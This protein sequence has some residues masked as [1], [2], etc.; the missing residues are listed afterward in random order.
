MNTEIDE[1]QYSR[2]LHTFGAEAQKALEHTSVLISGL[3]GLGVEI[4]KC[5]I[6][7]GV[8]SLTLH[9]TKVVDQI[10]L[11][12]NYYADLSDVGKMRTDVVKSKLSSLNPKVNVQI[13][14]DQVLTD[15]HA[16]RHQVVVICDSTIAEQIA[17]N[18]LF[19][20]YGTKY[21]FANTLGLFGNVFC[22]FGDEFIVSDPDG[23]TPV[24]GI[25]TNIVNNEFISSEP[26]KLYVGD[27]I[28]LKIGEIDY[29]D[30]VE[31]IVDLTT[32]KIKTHK[33]DNQ[34]LY[35][36]SFTQQK[37]PLTMNFK[38]LSLAITNPE[39]STVMIEDWDRQRLL[40]DWFVSVDKFVCI[41]Q[42]YP[43]S[44]SSTDAAEILQTI[45]CNN[46][47]QTSVTNLL[48]YTAKGK[49]VEIDSIIAPIV[50]QEVVK[51]ASKKYTPVKQF[52]YI[53]G[54]N[55]IPNAILPTEEFT[56]LPV[57]R[58]TG[59]YLVFGKT[60]QKKIMDSRVFVVGA[61]AI[62][63]E[64][65]KN[66]AMMGV[67][68]IVI[69]DMDTIEKSNLNRQFLFR[70]SDI[71]KSKSESA[72]NAINQMNPNITVVAQQNKV[73]GDTISVYN[74]HFFSQFSLVLTALDNVDAR[75]FVDFLC[76]QH[77]VPLIDAGTLGT[78]GNIQIVVP[79]LTETYG[80]SRDP[81]EK[82]IPMCTLKN[83]PYMIEHCIQWARDM[84]EGLFV[85]APQDFMQYKAN[86][87]KYTSLTE[88]DRNQLT[89][90][91]H[92][93]NF[94]KNNM[95]CHIKECVQIAYKLWHEHFRDHI[96]H[97]I[98]KFPEFS[99]T[100]EN[101][102]FWVGTKKFP[103]FADFTGTAI[104]MAFLES[105]ANLW[106]QVCGLNKKVTLKQLQ[107]FVE[108]STP[109]VIAG[110]N[111][112]IAENKMELAT[113]KP[114][115]DLINSL[116]SAHDIEPIIVRPLEFEKDDDTNFH[117]DFVTSASNSRATNYSIPIADKFKTKCI[118]GKI[119][120]AIVTTTSLVSGLVM[121]E[122]IKV[123][124]NYNK[125]EKYS[126][127][128]VNLALPVL[129]FSD[130]I[131]IKSNKVGNFAYTIWDRITFDDMTVSDLMLAIS[132]L[133][134]DDS[135]H[136]TAISSGPFQLFSL[137][138][139]NKLINERKLMKISDIYQ[140]IT[141]DGLLQMIPIMAEIEKIDAG[142]DMDVKEL[143]ELYELDELEDDCEFLEC[144]INRFLH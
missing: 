74:E 68:T 135:K 77:S 21:I 31:K 87:Q 54:T 73:C 11:S 61:G 18:E 58:Y 51:A 79:H 57:D 113:G 38:P 123:L 98:N 43:N 83:F 141:N 109:P 12:S 71:G 67:G 121:T 9:D 13:S 127:A 30:E 34:L 130:P 137:N 4:A 144:R 90:V 112:V 88:A 95:A 107:Q 94:V 23:E 52:M 24:F 19:R 2:Q 122:Y 56:D 84:F 48:S 7:T 36:S 33:F 55:M 140:K 76:L 46:E 27:T 35:N 99:V 118:A 65:L 47:I 49:L 96:Y 69:T 106:A 64:H 139:S 92:N 5:V 8:K 133:I 17:C 85:R 25:L 100:S 131:Q 50:G 86:P 10:D 60:L 132:N 20:Q 44:W 3:S 72:K 40:H 81:P 116:P 28:C 14:N 6:M 126:N 80:Q 110:L 104:E 115:S 125:I 89:E 103:K 142:D 101:L 119:I 42:R 124:Q 108:K 62:G 41:H 143:D 91:V 120:P 26:H 75:L 128:F 93:V 114:I 22:D 105:T 16:K 70:N 1:S 53:D 45:Q 59:R 117:V 29:I 37:Q 97:L 39:F 111:I 134:K 78:K 66:L 82:E 138:H 102:P 129:A 32:F 136:V 15:I 63:C